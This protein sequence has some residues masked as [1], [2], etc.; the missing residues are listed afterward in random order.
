MEIYSSLLLFIKDM[1]C[2]VQTTC[3][4]VSFALFGILFSAIVAVEKLIDFITI[5]FVCL[6]ISI[7]TVFIHVTFSLF[8]KML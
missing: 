2:K 3:F 6:D 7:C 8:L 4:N 5:K 1:A